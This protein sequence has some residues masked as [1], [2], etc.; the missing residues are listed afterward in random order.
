[1][2]IRD[3]PPTGLVARM[4][5]HTQLNTKM[6]EKEWQKMVTET[7]DWFGWIYYH[8]RPALTQAGKWA[9]PLQGLAGFPD[10]VLVHKTRGLVFA[11]LKSQTGRLT[12]K[13]ER[14]ID[15]LTYSGAEAHVW[16]PTDWPAVLRR[17]RNNP[18]G[19]K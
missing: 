19:N 2:P 14:W 7:A 12:D 1:M 3:R 8:S 15:L 9:T 4:T 13:Q 10:L 16:R 6:S 11:E 18:G 17:L 5:F